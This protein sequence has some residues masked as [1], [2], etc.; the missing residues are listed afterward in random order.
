MKKKMMEMVMKIGAANL[1]F[2]VLGDG[3][4]CKRAWGK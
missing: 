1:H 3:K 4:D 2:G